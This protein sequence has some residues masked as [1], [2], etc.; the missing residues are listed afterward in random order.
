MIYK[1]L[2][3]LVI[4]GLVIIRRYYQRGYRR[5]DVVVAHQVLESQ[6]SVIV[7]AALLLP[8]FL[9][10]FTDWLNYFDLFI[11]SWLRWLGFGL[12]AAGL[13]LLWWCHHVLGTN[14]Q[15]DIAIRREHKLVTQGPYA[16]IRH[17][18]YLSFILQGIGLTLIAANWVIAFFMLLPPIIAYLRRSKQEEVMLEEVFGD[19]YRDYKART[20]SLFPRIKLKRQG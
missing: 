12:G 7:T 14:W 11:P 17:P 4:L 8:I 15:P 18:M 16:F 9:Y 2:L 19:A 13:L 6:V 10:L 3:V 1:I 5:E 20:G